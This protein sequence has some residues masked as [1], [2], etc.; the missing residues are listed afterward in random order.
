V[1]L[2][3][4]VEEKDAKYTAVKKELDQTLKELEGL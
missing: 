1:E 2:E 3:R 4:S